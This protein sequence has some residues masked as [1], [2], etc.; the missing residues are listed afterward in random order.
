MTAASRPLQPIWWVGA[1]VL[2]C[3]IGALVFA[4]PLRAASLQLP[5][6]VFSFA[7]AFAWAVIRPSVLPP[8][9]LL[10]LGLFQDLLWGTPLGF[11]PLCLLSLHALILLVRASLSGQSF[12][13]L[14][15]WYSLGCAAAF[16]VGVALETLAAGIVPSLVGV[17][18]Q[19]LVSVALYPLANRLIDRYED[20]DVRFR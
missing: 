16:G 10:A 9:A 8:L 18:A 12:W 7:P 11:W 1:P 14:W 15:G 2:L 19:W 17:V 20:A 6:P 5:E 4:L 3:I 13:T